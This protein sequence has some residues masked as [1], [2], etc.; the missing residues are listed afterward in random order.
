M[1]KSEL[2][3]MIQE[4]LGGIVIKEDHSMV[5]RDTAELIGLVEKSTASDLSKEAIILALQDLVQLA[6]TSGFDEGFQY[7][8]FAITRQ[9][10][11]LQK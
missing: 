3:K 4:E 5:R 2:R 6:E 9:I 11:T 7:A 8:K 10:K 1:K